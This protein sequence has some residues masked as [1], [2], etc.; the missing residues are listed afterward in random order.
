LGELV[1]HIEHAMLSSIMG[2]VLDEVVRPD[3]IGYALDSDRRRCDAAN[4]S[5]AMKG[6]SPHNMID[7]KGKSTNACSLRNLISYFD[8][9]DRCEDFKNPPSRSC[10][11]ATRAA[12]AFSSGQFASCGWGNA[13]ASFTVSSPAKSVTLVPASCR[14]DSGKVDR[15]AISTVCALH[16]LA[17]SASVSPCST[18]SV[19]GRLVPALIV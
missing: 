14:G 19:V 9:A 2:A 17:A 13:A 8:Q 6:Q 11:S 5:C 16:S 12:T 4:D 10:S 1:Y 18:V 15:C 7:A 3:V